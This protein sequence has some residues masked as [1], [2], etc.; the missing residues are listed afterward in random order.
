MKIYN[1]IGTIAICVSERKKEIY[2]FHTTV[3]TF[4]QNSFKLQLNLA[5]Q[6]ECFIFCKVILN[7]T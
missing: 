6:V 1:E 2:L 5:H 3:F 4:A 7:E